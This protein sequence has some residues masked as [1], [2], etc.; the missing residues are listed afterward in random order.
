MGVE[1]T[2]QYSGEAEIFCKASIFN[3]SHC[4]F[5]KKK[6]TLVNV[7][8]E[9]H[10]QSSQI[11]SDIFSWLARW[12]RVAFLKTP[13]YASFCKYLSPPAVDKK[14][15]AATSYMTLKSV[16]KQPYAPTSLRLIFTFHPA[17]SLKG[18]LW[19]HSYAS[20]VCLRVNRL[21]N[22]AKRR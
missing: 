11:K 12:I 17:E 15:T 19:P 4:S 10:Q 3:Q 20:F 18:H 9:L 16:D 5:K 22:S 8:P 6:I 7:C 2:D 21:F 1:F 13:V 14:P